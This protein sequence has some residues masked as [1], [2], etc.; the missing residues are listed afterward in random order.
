VNT[1]ACSRLGELLARRDEDRLSPEEARLLREHLAACAPCA[2]EALR[3]DPV[4]LFAREAGSPA[5]VLGPAER[6]RFVADVLAAAGAARSRRRLR[7]RPPASL[8][9]I[10]ASLL[11]A[12]CLAGAW[13]VRGRLSPPGPETAPVALAEEPR[14]SPS[15]TPPAVEE[16]GAVGAVVYEF[17]SSAPGEPTVVFVVDRNADI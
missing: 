12:A 13:F 1:P 3:R 4:L 2:E 10:A 11:L 17:P 14:V 6:E 15:D 16:I 7:A 9:R 5:E 8:L